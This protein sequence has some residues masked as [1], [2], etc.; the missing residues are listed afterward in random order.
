MKTIPALLLIIVA[1]SQQFFYSNSETIST[2]LRPNQDIIATITNM[3]APQQLTALSIASAVG[4]VK[5]CWIRT[6]N[7]ST[8]TFFQGPM[9]IT[10]LSGTFDIKMQPHI[11]I[12]LANGKG[13]S[14]GGHLPSLEERSADQD[15]DC[16]IFTTLELVLLSHRDII[17]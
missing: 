16:P 10:A 1:H 11:H 6:A 13:D 17:Y 4:S 3:L 7:S 8:L 9:E 5:Y 12:Q 15:K 14:F 2:R